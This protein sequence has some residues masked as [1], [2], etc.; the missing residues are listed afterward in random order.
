MKAD[1]LA[2]L[3][4]TNGSA[5]HTL[6]RLTITKHLTTVPSGFVFGHHL[7]NQ[8]SLTGARFDVV[9]TCWAT[10]KR[11][12]EQ[13]HVSSMAITCSSNLHVE[14]LGGKTY[15]VDR[16]LRLRLK[17]VRRMIVGLQTNF[18]KKKASPGLRPGSEYARLRRMMVKSF[19][20]NVDVF[21]PT[22]ATNLVL[23]CF[24]HGFNQPPN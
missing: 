16:Q 10:I 14:R 7:S 24:G 1:Y 9:I 13:A 2:W 3:G 17:H 12:S 4:L 23:A 8:T 11:S 21:G 6:Q 20:H 22:T 19:G 5:G 18:I 15:F